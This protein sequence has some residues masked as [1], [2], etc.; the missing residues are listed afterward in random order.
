[1]STALSFAENFGARGTVQQIKSYQFSLTC[2]RLKN[3]IY[4]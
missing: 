1:L 2:Y 4:M 3:R